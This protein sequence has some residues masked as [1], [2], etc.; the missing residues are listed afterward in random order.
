MHDPAEPAPGLRP[1]DGITV[2]DMTMNI[3]GPCATLV[4]ADLGARVLKIEPPGGDASREWYPQASGVATVFS[5][6]NRNKESIVVD[7]RRPE[8]CKQLQRLVADA[9]VF[10]ESMR[11]GKADRL[12]LGWQELRAVNDRL[13]YCSINAFGSEGPMAGLAGFDAVIQAYSGLM[14]LTG[15]P[16]GDPARVGGAVVDVGTGAWSALAVLAALLQREHDGCGRRVSMTMLGTAV[17]YLMHHLTSTRLGGVEPRRLGTAQ[18]NFAPYQAV[19]AAD[20][21]VMLGVNSDAMWRRTAAA[22][23][24]PALADDARF[25]SNADRIAHRPEL[26]AAIEAATRQLD[27]DTVV[28]RLLEAQIPASVV[29]SIGALAHDPQLDALGLWGTTPSG[30]PLPRTPVA[31]PAVEIGAVAA[32][33]EHTRAVLLELGLQDHEVDAL[34]NSSVVDDGAPAGQLV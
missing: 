6:Y 1:L 2:V 8:G 12:G 15:Y 13:V 3:A 28:A 32:P 4:L 21:M 18:H 20:R 25:A 33:G 26:I 31:D 17:G 29:R 9:D 14:D 22:I 27:A 5:A 11:P 30:D 34:V 16:D 7:A 19:Q 24:N 23:G 10:V